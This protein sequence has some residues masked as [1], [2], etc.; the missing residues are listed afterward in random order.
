MLKFFW[1]WYERH[2]ALAV[3][4]ALALFLLQVVHLVWLLV[5]VIWTKL[6]GAPL[7]LFLLNTQWLHLFLITDEVVV[8]AFTSHTLIYIPA[9]LAWIAILIDYTEVPVMFDTARRFFMALKIGRR[10]REQEAQQ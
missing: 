7:Y 1:A 4:V 2:Y 10:E 3:G 9:W 6:S 8:A 5:E